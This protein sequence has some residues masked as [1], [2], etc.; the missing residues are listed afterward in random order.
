MGDDQVAAERSQPTHRLP[1]ILALAFQWCGAK[2]HHYGRCTDPHA[3][4]PTRRLVP[5][6]PQVLARTLV[7]VHYSLSARPKQDTGGR[8]P[9]HFKPEAGAP[10]TAGTGSRLPACLAPPPTFTSAARVLHQIPR[11]DGGEVCVP[12]SLPPPQRQRV[13]GLSAG[14][15]TDRITSGD[16]QPP[17]ASRWKL[18]RILPAGQPVRIA[19]GEFFHLNLT[20]SR[21]VG[22][23]FCCN[24]PTMAHTTRP[25]DT[26][27]ATS[28]KRT[29]GVA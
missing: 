25:E 16:E 27:P 14:S 26:P 7:Q 28:P 23:V 18:A 19:V 17:T 22:A 12:G 15:P 9:L 1:R 6:L 13:G 21:N 24:Y 5:S 2:W 3:V 11:L 8:K 20:L 29:L 10:A 4:M